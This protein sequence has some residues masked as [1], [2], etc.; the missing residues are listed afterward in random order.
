MTASGGSEPAWGRFGRHPGVRRL[1]FFL[2]FQKTVIFVIR[3]HSAAEVLVLLVQ[4]PKLE[5]L[6]PKSQSRA[7]QGCK[8]EGSGQSS[9]AGRFG[10]AGGVMETARE[11]RRLRPTLSQAGGKSLSK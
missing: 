10:L 5:L 1:S 9:L 8:S 3:S 11:R 6:G 7:V 2:F 4:A